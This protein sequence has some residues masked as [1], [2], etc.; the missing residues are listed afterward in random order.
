M[1]MNKLIVSLTILSVSAGFILGL[2][3]GVIYFTP[4]HHPVREK[5][6]CELNKPIYENGRIVGN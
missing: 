6:G 1:E 4:K 5:C 2:L 3:V